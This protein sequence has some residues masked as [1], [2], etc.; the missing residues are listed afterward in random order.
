[1]KYKDASI[2]LQVCSWAFKAGRCFFRSRYVRT[3][4]FMTEQEAGRMLFRY[5]Q[6]RN[7]CALPKIVQIEA[8][9]RIYLVNGQKRMW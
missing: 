4:A 3:D 7:F 6:R 2:D 8:S 1:M 9:S 5:E